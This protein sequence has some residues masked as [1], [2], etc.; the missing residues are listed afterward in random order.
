MYC[1]KNSKFEH[2]RFCDL[3]LGAK[4]QQLK[5]ANLKR[6]AGSSIKHVAIFFRLL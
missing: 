1:Y 5:A 6:I 2:P 4:G 3:N